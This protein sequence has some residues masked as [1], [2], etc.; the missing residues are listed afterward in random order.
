LVTELGSGDSVRVELN[1]DGHEFSFP[2]EVIRVKRR[3]E[4]QPTDFSLRFSDL[5]IRDAD[6]I[7]RYV[8]GVLKQRRAQGLV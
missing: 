5:S 1:L 3:D 4:D 6:R 8:F 7:R 2:A